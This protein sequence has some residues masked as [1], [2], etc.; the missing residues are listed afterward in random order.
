MAELKTSTQDELIRAALDALPIE[1][2]AFAQGYGELCGLR[3]QRTD[4]YTC[5]RCG[6]TYGVHRTPRFRPDA[7]VEYVPAPDPGC[8]K[9]E[10]GGV[11]HG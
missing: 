10:I 8:P 1:D 2:R 6:H 9:C 3:M 11:Y 7:T 4:M 5:A